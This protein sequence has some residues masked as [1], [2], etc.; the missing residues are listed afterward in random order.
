LCKEAYAE[1]VKLGLS[2]MDA[3]HVVAAARAG[4]KEFVTTEGI[5]KPIHK[6]SL[7]KVSPLKE[8]PLEIKIQNAKNAL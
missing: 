7:V 3:L 5:N 8:L 6:T 4:S 2:A 1:A